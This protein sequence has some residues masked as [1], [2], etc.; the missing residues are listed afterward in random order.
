VVEIYFNN[1]LVKQQALAEG[2]H[3]L[4]I[5][6]IPAQN[7]NKVAVRL[8]NKL[9]ED[10]LVDSNG[11]IVKDKFLELKKFSI[12]GINLLD[13]VAFY[14]STMQ[15]Y[16]Q[17]QSVEPKFGFWL[18]NSELSLEFANPFKHWYNQ[19]S[20]KN[21]KLA[22]TIV[23]PNFIPTQLEDEYFRNEIVEILQTIDY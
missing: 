17:G 22:A 15:Y 16:E 14:M 7:L 5:L 2:L 3:C 9:P 6:N 19:H 18:N 12:N 8:T 1:E 4:E 20:K 13:D 11:I 10:T 23:S 21:A